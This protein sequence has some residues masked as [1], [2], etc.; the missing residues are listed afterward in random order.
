MI[1]NSEKGMIMREENTS[2]EQ[3]IYRRILRKKMLT[4]G[5]TMSLIGLPV[6]LIMKLPYVWGL[7][8]LGIIVGGLKLQLLNRGNR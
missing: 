2:E 6:G 4:Y 7:A 8:D 5:F 3:A 1:T